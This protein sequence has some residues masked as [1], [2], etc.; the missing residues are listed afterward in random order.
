MHNQPLSIHTQLIVKNMTLPFCWCSQSDFL[1][2][3]PIRKLVGTSICTTK[4]N[5]C[6]G[7]ARH[8]VNKCKECVGS[9]FYSLCRIKRQILFGSSCE[10]AII[11]GLAS[12]SL[13]SISQFGITERLI[14]YKCS[15]N[16]PPPHAI[17][18][19]LQQRNEMS[20]FALRTVPA[21]WCPICCV[22]ID[23]Y[24]YVEHVTAMVKRI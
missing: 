14:Q 18:S 10:D 9:H 11:D 2:T 15:V 4:R 3:V 13:K 22:F 24:V 16:T 12:L 8:M 5:V 20:G 7:T 21:V 17:R 23:I 1:R 19:E 6:V